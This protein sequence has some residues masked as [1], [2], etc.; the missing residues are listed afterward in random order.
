M[1]VYFILR[2][3]KTSFSANQATLNGGGKPLPGAGD[4]AERF[5]TADSNVPNAKE[6]DVI[7]QKGDMKC[8]A[9]LHAT[10]DPSGEKLIVTQDD[11]PVAA[12]F[13][14]L[15]SLRFSAGS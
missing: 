4:R 13:G 10:A 1:V 12:Q 14:K 3:L 6:T 5:G 7:A 9:Q 2:G 11:R 15:C 8:Y